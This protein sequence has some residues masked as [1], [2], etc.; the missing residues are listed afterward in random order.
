MLRQLFV[1]HCKP[2]VKA[3]ESVGAG[4]D[5]LVN[6]AKVNPK[7]IVRELTVDEFAAITNQFSK[8]ENKPYID[9]ADI[10]TSI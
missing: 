5:V 7:K 10:V 1:N 6:R 8:W 4:G 3:I 2:V 9:D